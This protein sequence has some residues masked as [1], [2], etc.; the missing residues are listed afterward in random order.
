MPYFQVI[1]QTTGSSV[2][3]DVKVTVLD[4][5]GSYNKI[6]DL[7]ICKYLEAISYSS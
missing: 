4:L 2:D 5:L 7:V 6:L 1:L 3:I